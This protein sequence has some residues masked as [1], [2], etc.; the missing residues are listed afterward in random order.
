MAE[1]RKEVG[2]EVVRAE[3]V[4]AVVLPVEAVMFAVEEGVGGLEKGQ[5]VAAMGAGTAV[6]EEEERE[7]VEAGWAV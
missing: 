4:E 7:V 6:E 1:V 3:A 5:M 2:K